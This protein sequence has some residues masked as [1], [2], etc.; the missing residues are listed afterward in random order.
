MKFGYI[1]TRTTSPSGGSH[2][3]TIPISVLKETWGKSDGEIKYKKGF[4][5]CF[6]REDDK[7]LLELPERV[8]NSKDY[9]EELKEE[10]SKEWLRHRRKIVAEECDELY[11]K[12]SKGQISESEFDAR[13]SHFKDE[14]KQTARDHRTAFSER[15]LHFIASNDLGQLLAAISIDEEQEKEEALQSLAEDVK[16]F[17]DESEKMRD[18]LKLLEQGFKERR[19]TENRYE[20]LRELH[21]GKLTL[22]EDRLNR[23]KEVLCAP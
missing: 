9:S 10:V 23:L 8:L 2:K 7:T 16:K 18:V 11:V 17:Q 12:L 5:V 15:E 22:A 6:I 3:V 4:Q 1:D 21:K 13:F 14:F 19:I 20:M